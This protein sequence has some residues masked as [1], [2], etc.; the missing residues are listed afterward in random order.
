MGLVQME[1][2]MK[3][4]NKIVIILEVRIG[5]NGLVESTNQVSAT[6][7]IWKRKD[8]IPKID[9]LINF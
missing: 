1:L 5:L 3:I 6:W 8:H 4:K 9:F 7:D 2:N